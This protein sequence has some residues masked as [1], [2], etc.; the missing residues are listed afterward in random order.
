[1]VVASSGSAAQAASS[2]VTT[3]A[4]RCYSMPPYH[5]GGV[6]GLVLENPQFRKAWEEE[7]DQ[8]RTRMNELRQGLAD[9]LNQAQDVMDFS[10]I[11]RTRGMFCFLGVPEQVVLDLRSEFGIY[12][13]NSTRINI[14]GLSQENLPVVISRV[15]EV[16]SR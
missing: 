2:H 8:V 13:L 3:A 10:F 6:A 1:M 14:A 9:G 11:G 5:G 7:L 15:A 12:F 4:R 16:L